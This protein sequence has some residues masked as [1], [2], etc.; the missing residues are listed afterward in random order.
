MEEFVKNPAQIIAAENPQ[1]SPEAIG[2]LMTSAKWGKF[3]AILGFISL[4]F[5]LLAGLSM[6]LLFNLMES[7]SSAFAGTAMLISPKWLAV[8]Y[9]LISVISFVPVYFLNSF[10][11]RVTRSVRN[12]DTES[13]TSAF[14]QLKNLFVFLGIYTIAMIA[15]YIIV[16]IVVA[17]AAALAV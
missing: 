14:R 9:I 1:L 13:M 7:R 12:N 4:G 16:I 3:L 2:F 10:S 15:V 8:I 5:L 11:N 17:S 6:G